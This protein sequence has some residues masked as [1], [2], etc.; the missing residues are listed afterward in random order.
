MPAGICC[1]HFH[2]CRSSDLEVFFKKD[3]PGIFRIITGEHQCKNAISTY[4]YS[5]VIVQHICSKTPFLRDS[6]GDLLLC[7]IL[8]IEVTNVEILL[9]QVKSCSKYISLL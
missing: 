4:G 1:I 9:K 8:N 2:I 6:S 7:I 3:V 5:S